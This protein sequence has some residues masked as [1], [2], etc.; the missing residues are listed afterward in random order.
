VGVFWR[1]IAVAVLTIGASGLAPATLSSAATGG[2]LTA[3]AGALPGIVT[4]ADAVTLLAQPAFLAAPSG[5]FRLRLLV[6]AHDPASEQ[7]R[8][9]VYARLTT[10]TGFD[11]ALAGQV[12][13]AFPIYSIYPTDLTKLP[14]D[15]AGGVDVDIP[16]NRPS[17]NLNI[18]T[19]YAA[20]GSGV[21]PIQVGI[22]DTSDNR[23]GQLLTTYLVYAEPY[24]ASG[25]PKLSVS[26]VLPVHSAPTVDQK[27]QIGAL[28]PDQSRALADLVDGLS[29]HLDVRLSLAVTPQTLDSLAAGSAL[30]RSTLTELAQLVEAGHVQILPSTYVSVP[31]RG[32]DEVG[33][34]DELT[35]QLNSGSSILG[36]VFGA[37][38][39]PRTWVINGPVDSATLNK[40]VGRGATQFILPDAEL[41][42]LPPVARTT[43]FALPAE[44]L[45][46]DANPS[47][48][49]ADSGL[50]ADFSNRGGPVLAA[51]QLLAE[52]A[53]IQLET[54][55]L[56]RGVAVLPPPGWS[57]DPT[58]VDTLLAGLEDHPLLNPVT[59]AGLF[60]AVPGPS[61]Q[62]SVAVPLLAPAPSAPAGSGGSGSAGSAGSAGST[63]S[64]S[65]SSGS[66]G[67]AGPNGSTG[68]TSSTATTISPGLVADV[69]AQ[70]G[71]D[72]AAIRSARERLSGLG[73]I[74]P[75][76]P[77]QAQ[78]L[79]RDLLTSESSD[80]T[81]AQR[82][83]LLGTIFTAS[84]RVTSLISLPRASSI[85]LTSTKGEVPLTVLSA[86][87][88]RARVQ[89]RL[90]SQRLIFHLSFPPEGKCRIPTP[91]SEVCD[92]TLTTQNTTLK[93]PVETRASGV[94]PLDVSLWTPD[95]S[96][97]LARNRDTVRS[98]AVSGV[99]IILI[100]VAVLSLA[101]WWGRDL[102]YGRRA[103][104]LVPAPGDEGEYGDGDGSVDDF[105]NGKASA[106]E[107]GD[108]LSGTGAAGGPDG[109]VR[110]FFATPAPE[111]H[112]RPSE[113]RP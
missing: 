14:A 82:Q 12:G 56:T 76:S 112:Q 63:G 4:G 77:E 72:A 50:T 81:E 113:P 7:I 2:N 59:A 80:L 89:L 21:F 25:L 95:G 64:G 15:P 78:V 47:V 98:T 88:L 26:L 22:Y 57:P 102:R 91:T 23:Q 73:A 11:N 9:N 19:F 46:T 27:G 105:E 61:V 28:P 85:T 34:D 30:D 24:S 33:L 20:A 13:Q 65:G 70:L 38:P 110:E 37:A 96:Q 97:M 51:D 41:S 79:D 6:S 32:W 111:Y 8:V 75:Q 52:L 5:E 1:A 16:I 108:Q 39:S 67:S 44:L 87:S 66:E 93:V 36:A 35:R 100:A 58:F 83:G 54:P 49:A 18:P 92:L 86:P 53:M 60:N 101:I 71:G 106:D 17:T 3:T 104:R 84:N 74:L 99:G 62:R 94:F 42:A 31:M 109:P 43:T 69:A 55:G 103:R 40:L 29:R 10:R 107:F 90:S 48:Y 45:G 68:S